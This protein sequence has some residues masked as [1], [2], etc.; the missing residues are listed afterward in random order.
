MRAVSAQR[1]ALVNATGADVE[2]SRDDSAC[3]GELFAGKDHP[4]CKKCDA[5]GQCYAAWRRK[6]GPKTSDME[7][8][9]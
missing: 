4:V 3:F 1:V 5:R 9:E 8:P 7:R 2:W 6:Y